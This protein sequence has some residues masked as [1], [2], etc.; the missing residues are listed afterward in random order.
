MSTGLSNHLSDFCWLSSLSYL[1]LLTASI[2]RLSH[3][4]DSYLKPAGLFC[5]AFSTALSVFSGTF[6][7]SSTSCLAGD[8]ALS[9]FLWV[10]RQNRQRD[11]LSGANTNGNELLRIV[12]Q[13]YRVIIKKSF[14]APKTLILF[15]FKFPIFIKKYVA[16]LYIYLDIQPKYKG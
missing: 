14:I 7:P 4:L 2:C 13:F 3:S 15:F 6:L 9:L 1:H 16:F 12:S 8:L 11:C 10:S 5:P